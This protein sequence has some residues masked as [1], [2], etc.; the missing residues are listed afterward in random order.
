MRSL[1][2][3]VRPLYYGLLHA[4]CRFWG[5]LGAVDSMVFKVAEMDGATMIC[6]ANSKRKVYLLILNV[7][8]CYKVP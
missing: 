5:H 2:Q 4:L 8:N 7:G 1:P 3:G 6:H